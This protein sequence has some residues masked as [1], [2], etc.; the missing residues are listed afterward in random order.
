MRPGEVSMGYV[1]TLVDVT[2]V[3]DATKVKKAL[4]RG[5]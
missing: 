5:C 4:A 1:K 2:V 3:T